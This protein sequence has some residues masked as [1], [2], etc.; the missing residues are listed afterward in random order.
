MRGRPTVGLSDTIRVT[1]VDILDII[2]KRFT[3]EE[4][5]EAIRTT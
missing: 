1:N 3:H 2:P 4:S 5:M